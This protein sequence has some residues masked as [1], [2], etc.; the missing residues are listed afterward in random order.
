MRVGVYLGRHAGGGGGIGIYARELARALPALLEEPMNADD[1]LVLYGDKSVLTEMLRKDLALSPVLTEEVEGLFS[2]GASSYFRRL[3][4]GARARVLVRVLPTFPTHHLAMLYDQLVLPLV[5]RR[6]SLDLLHATGNHMLLLSATPQLVTVHD[7]YQGWPI[8]PEVRSRFAPLYRIFFAMQFRRTVSVLTDT[9]EVAQ[10]I[11]RRFQFPAGRVRTVRLGIDSPFAAT[12][13]DA[14]KNESLLREGEEFLRRHDLSAGYLLVFGSLDPRKN[15]IHTLRAWR[16]LPEEIKA[17]GLVVRAESR[18]VEAIVKAECAE[19]FASARVK[20]IGWLDRQ[21]MPLL[22]LH[23][24]LLVV[25]TYAEGFGLPAAEA[26]ALRIPAVTGP[27]ERGGDLDGDIHLACN[28]GDP[29]AIVKA[30]RQ[31][32]SDPPKISLQDRIARLPD[33]RAVRSM[34]DAARESFAAYRECVVQA[35]GGRR[36]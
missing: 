6:D 11:S 24:N 36:R 23:A 15:L 7:L 8:R 34:A 31:L 4:N 26:Q 25:P 17:L 20:L 28:P 29:A 16:A 27:I 30:I 12:L 10:E 2:R 18:A 5:V 32:I 1:E 14:E 13:C 33:R 9:N 35:Q 22:Y 19:D 21:E 3:P